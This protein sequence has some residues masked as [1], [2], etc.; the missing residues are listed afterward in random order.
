MAVTKTVLWA[1]VRVT[2]VYHA[3]NDD[4]LVYESITLVDP[5]DLPVLLEHLLAAI[6]CAEHLLH[7]VPA[8]ASLG[9]ELEPNPEASPAPMSTAPGGTLIN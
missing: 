7:V 2:A 4:S 6:P 1:G 8:L 5:T 3:P 9:A